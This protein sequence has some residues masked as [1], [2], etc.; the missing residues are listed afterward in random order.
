MSVSKSFPIK[1]RFRFQFQAEFLNVFNHPT[2]GAP[3]GSI[4]STSFGHESV[5]NSP[6]NIEFRGNIIF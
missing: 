6:R 5:A 2:F 1:E 3:N 4:L